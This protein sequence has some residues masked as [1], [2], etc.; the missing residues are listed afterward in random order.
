MKKSSS[1]AGDWIRQNGHSWGHKPK[2]YHG[3]RDA[4]KSDPQRVRELRRRVLKQPR[5]Q[6]KS[7][8]DFVEENRHH[9][10]DQCLLI[11]AAQ[12]GCPAQVEFCGSL[13]SAARYMLLLTQGT[14]KWDEA[15][16]THKC[17]N[18]HLSCVNPKHLRWGDPSTNQSDAV[19]HRACDTVAEKIS[20]VS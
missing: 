2:A 6:R 4:K 9:T 8:K 12:N 15:W 20:K 11:P 7:I 17:G 13:I 16:A 5:L 3:G 14:A 19:M 18:G 1:E 10:G